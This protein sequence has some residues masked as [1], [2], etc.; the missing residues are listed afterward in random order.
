MGG[1]AFKLPPIWLENGL[2]DIFSLRRKNRNM[3]QIR[4]QSEG[5]HEMGGV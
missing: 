5:D 3:R 1:V 2:D 4:G